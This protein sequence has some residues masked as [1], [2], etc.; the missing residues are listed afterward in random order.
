MN[1][2]FFLRVILGL[3]V[4]FS[5]VS[6]ATAKADDKPHVPPSLVKTESDTILQFGKKFGEYFAADCDSLV[7][8]ARP[9]GQQLK[10]CLTLIKELRDKFGAFNQAV[11]SF[12]GKIKNAG[13]WTKELDEDFAQNA[14]KRGAN[15]AIVDEANRNGGLRN[16]YEKNLGALNRL[17]VEMDAEIKTLENLQLKTALSRNLFGELLFVKA[18]SQRNAAAFLSCK[19]L[20]VKYVVYVLGMGVFGTGGSGLSA[21]GAGPLI[22]ARLDA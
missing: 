6:A 2:L 13:K 9:N 10:R 18:S 7:E 12:P 11:N 3:A 20:A 16:F 22:C 1:H 15:S 5:G 14:V 4:L 17:K 21:S 8:E 19:N